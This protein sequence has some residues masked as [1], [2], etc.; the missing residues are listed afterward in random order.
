M[1]SL[2]ADRHMAGAVS[3]GKRKQKTATGYS[4]QRHVDKRNSQL[5]I[6]NS[7]QGEKKESINMPKWRQSTISLLKVFTAQS[8]FDSESS[9]PFDYES[10][11]NL[12]SCFAAL[13]NI[14]T[15]GHSLFEFVSS[16]EALNREDVVKQIDVLKYEVKKVLHLC[17]NSVNYENSVNERKIKFNKFLRV[18][19]SRQENETLQYHA[20]F[21][22]KFLKQLRS[23]VQGFVRS[24]DS[25]PKTATGKGDKHKMKTEMKNWANRMK[26]SWKKMEEAVSLIKSQK[27]RISYTWKEPWQMSN[28]REAE[29]HGSVLRPGGEKSNQAF[30]GNRDHK[31]TESS[32]SSHQRYEEFWRWNHFDPDDFLQE[33][34]F[35][36]NQR[37]WHKHQ[38]RLRKINGRIQRLTEEI[39]LSMDDDDI[40][41]IYEDIDDFADDVEDREIP[42]QLRTWLSCQTRWWR[43]RVHRK[44]RNEDLVKGCGQQLMHWQLRV[45]CKEKS[46][47]RNQKHYDYD[48]FCKAV[49]SSQGQG[50]NSRYF[51]MDAS[52]FKQGAKEAEWKHF[53]PKTMHAERF[54]VDHLMKNLSS[55]YKVENITFTDHSAYR[56]DSFST[57]HYQPAL[58]VKSSYFANVAALG[59][60]A[61]GHE[62]Q[63]DQSLNRHE[64]VKFCKLVQDDKQWCEK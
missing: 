50:L 26:S 60:A 15:G 11:V 9:T 61:T 12:T 35:E 28:V 53:T 51:V 13:Q 39:L 44:H 56:C 38:K 25:F 20:K 31:Q 46:G 45:L 22:Q 42:E 41:D 55:E 63:H 3:Y 24:I 21:V 32:S 33:G 54:T 49:I 34:F 47:V 36:D 17:Q 48:R 16:Q 18:S 7:N 5:K 37:E 2:T 59:H 62:P 23:V 10:I 43:S 27:Q 1:F 52:L 40:E 6:L 19:M 64:E 30:D 14:S 58:L 57:H 4:E 8:S 29:V